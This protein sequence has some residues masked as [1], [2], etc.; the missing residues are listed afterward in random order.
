MEIIQS[1]G[2]RHRTGPEIS[3]RGL[4]DAQVR[5]WLI[6]IIER[7]GGQKRLQQIYDE[8]TAIERTPADFW[9][10][11][12]KLL[13]LRIIYNH[14]NLEKVPRSGPLIIIANHP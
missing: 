9:D 6:R 8:Y 4:N 11:S 14:E 3:Y 7:F 13:N 2:F 1:K 12:I 5:G 10:D